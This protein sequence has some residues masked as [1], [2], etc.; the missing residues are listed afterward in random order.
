MLDQEE[1]IED[2]RPWENWNWI[3]IDVKII[4]TLCR[5]CTVNAPIDGIESNVFLLNSPAQV[6]AVD[7]TL[8][9][10]SQGYCVGYVWVWK[11]TSVNSDVAFRVLFLNNPFEVLGWRLRAW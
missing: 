11:T 5:F 6:R 2:N 9:A 4:G 8:E 3:P 10:K 7:C 1:R